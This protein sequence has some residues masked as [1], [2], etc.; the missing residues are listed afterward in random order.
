MPSGRT[1]AVLIKACGENPVPSET[2]NKTP[3]GFVLGAEY[4][5]QHA[6]PF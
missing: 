3:M 6:F 1:I 4:L 2:K 5:D